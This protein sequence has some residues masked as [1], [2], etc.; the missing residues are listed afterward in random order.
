MR[1]SLLLEHLCGILTCVVKCCKLC[2]N[3]RTVFR[4]S[5]AKP[6]AGRVEHLASGLTCL[7]EV[8]HHQRNKE[9]ALEVLLI[10]RVGKEL[11]K[12]VFAILE[13]VRRESPEVHADGSGV[14]NAY[15]LVVLVEILHDTI[16]TFNLRAF[17]DASKMPRLTVPLSLKV[18]STR[19][20]TMAYLPLLPSGSSLRNFAIT[21]K[22]SR[23]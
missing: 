15:P 1:P 2:H 22:A 7:D 3:L 10:L 17:Y 23:S 5:H 11:L 18:L 8:I 13:V 20:P 19:K 14:W 6:F 16:V 4:I 9:L 21:R 12:E